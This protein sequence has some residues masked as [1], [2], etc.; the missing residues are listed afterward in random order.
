MTRE[1]LTHQIKQLLDEVLILGSMVEQATLNAISTL[2]NRDVKAARDV[3]DDDAT[4]NEKRFAI[5]NAIIITIATQQPMARD[6][7]TLAAILEIITEL[8]RMGDY[9]KGIA[10]VTMRLGDVEI[11]IPMRE[12]E[13]MGELGVGMLHRALSAF[14]EED[15]KTASKIP[16][17]DD[18]VDAIYNEMYRGLVKQMITDPGLIESTN[19]LLWVAHNLERLADRVTN[20]CERT[21]FI[22]TGELMEMDTADDEENE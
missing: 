9:A 19:L 7:R 13:K 5:E 4:I 10:K 11:P 1:L 17:E 15:A 18:A 3:Y 6:L 20:I 21:V 2:K 16:V 12:I 14:V 8:E 22:T